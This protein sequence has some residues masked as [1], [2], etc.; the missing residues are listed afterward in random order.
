M[1][2]GIFA[3]TFVRPTLEATLDAVK[4]HGLDCVQFNMACAGLPTLPEQ[5][6]PEICQRIRRETAA[7]GITIAAVSGT[8]NMIH[9]DSNARRAGLD[10]LEVLAEACRD[11]GTSIITLCT[12]TRDRHDMWRRHPDNNTPRAWNHLLDSMQEVVE[13]AEAC[14]VTMAFEPEV[15]NVVDSAKKARRLLD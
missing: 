9:R 15:N 8:F 4:A 10:A 1:R 11:L 3:K 5:I 2:L 6:D 7:R 12:G 13:V 14:D